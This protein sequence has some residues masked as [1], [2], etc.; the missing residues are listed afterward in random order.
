M[1]YGGAL[2]LDTE[3]TSNK[4]VTL[5]IVLFSQYIHIAASAARGNSPQ[6]HVYVRYMSMFVIIY[7]YILD[8]RVARVGRWMTRHDAT[9]RLVP[10]SDI[11]KV[12]Q[13]T[14]TCFKIEFFP[15]FF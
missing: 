7:L 8:C 4:I 10:F 1:F 12:H 14:T 3:L 15:I 5:K 13:Q 11:Y 6:K 9:A 2:P